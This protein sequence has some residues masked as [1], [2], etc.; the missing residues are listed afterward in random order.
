MEP[1]RNPEA[2]EKQTRG[3]VEHHLKLAGRSN[4]LFTDEA[5][6]QLFV[7]SGGVPRVIGNIA[8]AAMTEAAM[9][10]RDLVELDE[11]ITASKEV[12]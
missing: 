7:Q 1:T 2:P 9:A 3:Y 12:V 6:N 4:G 5:M 8:L 11:V 10:G